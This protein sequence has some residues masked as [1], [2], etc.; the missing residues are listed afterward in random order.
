MLDGRGDYVIARA[1]EAKNRQVIAL[2]T[3]AGEDDFGGTR[4]D[5]RSHGVARALDCGPGMLAMM[6]DGRR[7]AELFEKK[8][9]G[10]VQNFGQHGRGG[11]VIE[12]DPAHIHIRLYAL[13]ECRKRRRVSPQAER[14][15]LLSSRRPLPKRLQS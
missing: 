9:P 14:E 1:D 5:Q 10:R 12:I 13:A 3:A 4:A 15:V 7:V 6:M 11:V 2:S 8:W